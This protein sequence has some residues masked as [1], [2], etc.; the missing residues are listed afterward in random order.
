MAAASKSI[1]I[2]QSP[3]DRDVLGY[4]GEEGSVINK[5]SNPVQSDDIARWQLSQDVS[6]VLAAIIAEAYAVGRTGPPITGETSRD[7][8]PTQTASQPAGQV[9]GRPEGY[10]IGIVAL[11]P[12]D[13]HVRFTAQAT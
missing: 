12:G 9:H 1:H 6:T 2:G 8:L 5:A 4:G 10:N 11:T 3:D 7:L 13:Q